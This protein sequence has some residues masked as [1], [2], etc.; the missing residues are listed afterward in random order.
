MKHVFDRLLWLAYGV[1]AGGLVWQAAYH[2]SANPAP[3]PHDPD[4]QEVWCVSS[5]HLLWHTVCDE[6][7]MTVGGVVQGV[8]SDGK[9]F[10]VSGDCVLAPVGYE[11][12]AQ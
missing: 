10:A 5:G 1:V 3:R 9:K 6:C 8:D 11:P 12:G 2:L 4:Q 7:H